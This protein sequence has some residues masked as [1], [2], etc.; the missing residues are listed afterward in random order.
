MTDTTKITKAI[1]E[2][3]DSNLFSFR[4]KYQYHWAARMYRLFA[5]DRYLQ[6][7]YADYQK[8]TLTH[9]RRIRK[10]N[11]PWSAK[12]MARK[13]LQGYET[14]TPKKKARLAYYQHHP[15]DFILLNLCHWLFMTKTYNLDQLPGLSN[16]FAKG[17]R[18]VKRSRFAKRLLD[19]EFI[20][21]NPSQVANTVYYLKYL[22]VADQEQ[23]IL[24]I[25]KKLWLNF[26]PKTE[27][28]W[29]NKIYALTHLI[30]PATHFY[31]RFV[32]KDNFDWIL[33]FFENNFTEITANTNPD[34]VAE[35][36]LCFKLCQ[37]ENPLVEK[38]MQIVTSS[39]NESKGYI[40]RE[41]EPANLEKAEHRN[42]VAMLLLTPVTK[43]NKGPDIFAYL[44]ENK[45]GIF[46]PKGGQYVGV[47]EDDLL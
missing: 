32:T 20:S 19:E 37:T 45:R 10:L 3:F 17:I 44:K 31:Q 22:E 36:G 15:A 35:I 4:L 43:F 27:V 14:E 6:P 40:P 24:A 30:I 42:A 18:Y 21:T 12:K 5:D 38:V 41:K 16:Y 1:K 33:T 26:T 23:E 39:Y 9:V 29:Q 11:F 46:I 47:E 34:I 2:T 7:I 13:V 25:Y 28:D 8:R